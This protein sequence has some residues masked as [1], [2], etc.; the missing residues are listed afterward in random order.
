[1]SYKI[2]RDGIFRYIN[3]I[4]CVLY[5]SLKKK[6][7]H[8]IGVKVERYEVEKKDQFTGTCYRTFMEHLIH[9]PNKYVK[10]CAPVPTFDYLC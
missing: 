5:M 8:T 2:K 9:F 10:W 1:M 6:K 4:N 7:M 3:E